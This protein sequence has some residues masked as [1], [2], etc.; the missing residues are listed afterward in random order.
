MENN[1]CWDNYAGFYTGMAKSWMYSGLGNKKLECSPKEG[2]VGVLVDGEL[3]LGSIFK[4][5]KQE[6]IHLYLMQKTLIS[7][8]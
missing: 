6:N 4:K 7:N 1:F 2:D 5:Q 3:S 8:I